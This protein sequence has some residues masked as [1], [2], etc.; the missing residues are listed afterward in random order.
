MKLQYSG[1]N[2]RKFWDRI[3]AIKSEKLQS[4]VYLAGCALQDHESQVLAMIAEA[5]KSDE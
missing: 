3:N 1:A 2:S 5:E 4:L